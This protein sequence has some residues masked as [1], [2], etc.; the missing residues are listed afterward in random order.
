MPH[1]PGPAHQCPSLAAP[2]CQ[3]RSS[4]LL[5]VCCSFPNH[6]AHQSLPMCTDHVWIVGSYFH[7]SVPGGFDEPAAVDITPKSKGPFS[8]AGD[9]MY[10]VTATKKLEA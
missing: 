8:P 3:H 6:R 4:S 7:Y 10:V 1:Y 9:P 5:P 2:S